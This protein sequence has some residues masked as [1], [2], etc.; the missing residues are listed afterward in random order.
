LFKN[1][2]VAKVKKILKGFGRTVHVLIELIFVVL[3]FVAFAIRTSWFQT[4]AAQQVAS[5]L[6]SEW[7]TD[8]QIEKVDFI[9]F[10]RLDIEGIYV[11]DKLNDTLLSSGTVRVEIADWSLSESFVELSRVELNDA[12]IQ[13]KKY[14]GDSTLNFQHI[15]DYFASDEPEDTTK[16]KFKVGVKTIALNNINFAYQ[17]QNAAPLP[18]GMDFSNLSFQRLSGELSDFGLNGDSIYVDVSHFKLNEKSGLILTELSTELLFCPE[19]VSLKDLRIGLNNSYLVSD[20]FQL[21]TPNGSADFANFVNNVKFNANIRD[22]K[23]S[24]ADVAFFVPTI[25]GMTDDVRI[26]NI[27][28]KGPVYGMKL[29]NTEIRLLDTTLIVGDFEIPDMSDFNSAFFEEKVD[30]FR[31]SVADI[32]KLNLSPFLKDGLKNFNVPTSLESANVV[33]LENVSFIG[34]IESFVV[35]GDVYSGLGTVHSEYGIQF[36]KKED[37]LYHYDG[38]ENK[39]QG[40]D[41]IVSNVNLQA[42]SG[43][44]T[45]GDIS[46]YFDINGKGFSQKDLNVNFVGELYSIGLNGYDYTG[47]NVR[48]GNFSNNV[49]TGVIDIEDDNLALNYDGKVDLK[50]P[51]FFDFSIKIDSAKLSELHIGNDTIINNFNADIDVKVRG[52]SINELSGDISIS[53]LRYQES[54][55]DFILDTLSLKIRRSKDI[56]TISLFSPY[57]DLDVTGKFDLMDIYPVLMTQMSYVVDHLVEA[58]D[59]AKTKNKYFD[60]TIDLKNVNPILQFYD[61]QIYISEG[62]MINSYYNIQEKRFAF[63][64]NINKIVYHDMS[65]SEIKIENHFDSLKA[66]I[67]WQAQYGKL[68]DSLQVRN[69][70]IDSYVK[71]NTFITNFGWD[72][73]NGTQPA[74]FAFKTVVDEQKNVMTDFD[75]SF[76]FLK[77]DKWVIN[78]KS[79]ILWNIDV[80]QLTKFNIS[81]ENRVVS[82]NGKISKNPRDWLYFNVRD[83]DLSDLNALFGGDLTLGGILNINGGIADLYDNIRFEVLSDV[84]DFVLNDELVGNLM[85]GGQWD[86]STNSVAVDGSLNRNSKP[87]FTFV[88]NYFIGKAEDN[89]A[90][91][92]K[93]KETDISFLSAF[94]D[95][96]LYSE[97]KGILSGELKVSGELLNP[98]IEGDLLVSKASVVVPMFNV[99]FGFAGKVEFGEG[100]III[101]KMQ[102]F[103]Q[104][105]NEAQ[106][107]I[108]I[109]HEDWSGWNYDVIL[110]FENPKLSKSFLV[111][112]TEYK[113]GSSYYGKAY[114]SGNVNIFGYGDLVQIGVDATTEK[115]T[116]LVLPMFGSSDLEETSFIQ[117]TEPYDSSMVLVQREIERLGMTLDMKFKVTKDAKVTI[118]F[119]PVYGDQI[120][121]DEGIGTIE[122]NVDNYGEMTMFGKYEIRKGAYN[123]RMKTFVREDFVIVPGSTVAWNGSPFDADIAIRAQFERNLSLDDIMPPGPKRTKKDIVYGYLIM[124]NTLMDP[125][126]SFEIKAPK[127]DQ[128]GKDAVAALA[129]DP[130]MLMK[131]FFSLLVLQRFIPTKGSDGSGSAAYGLLEDQVNGLLSGIGENYDL[132]ANIGG[133]TSTLGFS[134]ALGEKFTVSVSGGVVE[135]GAAASSLVGDVR[136]EYSVNEDGSFTMNFFNESNTGTEAEQGPFTQG[137]SLHY[138]ETFETVRE[139]RLLQGFLDIFRSDTNDVIIKENKGNKRHTPIPK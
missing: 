36:S 75:P 1:S 88:G 29:K 132:A 3:F 38:P 82:F 101:Q 115:G 135:D 89:I 67:N 15:I 122:I 131:Q 81:N 126:L 32:E 42:I 97:I 83:F 136:V 47:I 2:P 35:D 30:T 78:D 139:F 80:I 23:I 66:N 24:L 57:L 130:D 137:V 44:S 117:F 37:G 93:F 116:D 11:A 64:I 84:T 62:S 77:D 92:L 28:I 20:Y 108:S 129:S 19:V 50:S 55:I 102:L 73:H 14:K 65:L 48:K 104:E 43:N 16:S 134:T 7:G 125:A 5:Y 9:F 60:L 138:E 4:W 27:E 34:G 71:N 127:A 72:G 52:T 87:T 56:D 74:L 59:I 49:F 124:S 119:E 94:E 110:D 10:D 70:Y 51:M 114:I 128:E 17:D 86:K 79:K 8:V 105:K 40:R 100:E 13:I 99:P 106:A 112:N 111:M 22:S 21:I 39:P 46:G 33:L 98:D 96:I 54:R 18:N 95:P 113:E 120:V 63:D 103:D 61:D 118:V 90:L 31:T 107:Q 121:V 12:H 76:F 133:G 109:Y 58:K 26:E 123:M 68:N 25:W 69:L 41:I 85:I 45:L 6:S 53:N 91:T